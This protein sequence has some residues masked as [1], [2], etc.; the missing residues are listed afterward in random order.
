[1]SLSDNF[2]H[3]ILRRPYRLEAAVAGEGPRSIILLHGIASD[4]GVW[5][6]LIKQLDPARYRVIVP[7]LLGFGE[8]PKPRWLNYTVDDHTRAVIAVLRKHHLKHPAIL[9]GHSMGCLIATHIATLRPDSVDQLIL[10]EPPLLGEIPDYPRHTKRSARY[11]TVFEF[12]ASHP[13]L[14]HVEARLLWRIARKLWGAH[15]SREEWLPFERSLRNTILEQR[16][17]DELQRIS[18]PTDI[19]Y[20]RLDPIVIRRGIERM[21]AHNKFVSLHVVTDFHGVSTRSAKYIV[22]LFDRIP[23]RNYTN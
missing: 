23:S 14:A 4:G 11:K 18:L 8:S 19:I 22:R 6:P 10:Y 12:I 15:L 9:V 3:R 20:G 17:Y 5:E 2:W 13:Q 21:F 7:D 16:A 1:M